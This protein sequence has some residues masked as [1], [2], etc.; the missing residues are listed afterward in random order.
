MKTKARPMLFIKSENDTMYSDYT[1][2]PVS[3]VSCSRYRDAYYDE[4]ITKESFP[5]TNLNDDPSYIR[6]H[7]ISTVSS[8]EVDKANYLCDFKSLYPEKY[9]E[10]V[11]KAQ[12][13]LEDI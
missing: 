1:T 5:D 8:R 9:S 12:K 7:K 13:Y 2:L 10:I 4:K 3:K 11:N 6:C